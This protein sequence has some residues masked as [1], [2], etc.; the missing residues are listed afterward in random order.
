MIGTGHS[1][2]ESKKLPFG[3]KSLLLSVFT[4]TPT[5]TSIDTGRIAGPGRSEQPRLLDVPVGLVDELAP[6]GAEVVVEG[7]GG[8]L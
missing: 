6:A 5:V 4:V 8:V 2:P 1:Q 3:F 7:G